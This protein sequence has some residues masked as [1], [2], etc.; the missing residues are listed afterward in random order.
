MLT[1]AYCDSEDGDGIGD[2]LSL[3]VYVLSVLLHP[4]GEVLPSNKKRLGI[5]KPGFI[6]Q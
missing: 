5:D 2:S 6:Y 3:P 1:N 4:P